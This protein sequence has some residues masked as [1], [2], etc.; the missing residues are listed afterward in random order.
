MLDLYPTFALF[1][2]FA[3]SDTR[4]SASVN[5]VLFLDLPIANPKHTPMDHPTITASMFIATPYWLPIPF[6]YLSVP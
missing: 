1:N 2:A 5:K 3:S 4:S 6:K